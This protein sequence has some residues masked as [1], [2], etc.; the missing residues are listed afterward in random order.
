MGAV[1]FEHRHTSNR[2]GWTTVH[3]KLFYPSQSIIFSI[4]PAL[5]FSIA[6]NGEN[7]VAPP[8]HIYLKQQSITYVMA[9]QQQ[10]LFAVFFVT[11][12]V[13]AMKHWLAKNERRDNG[14]VWT[15][16]KDDNG[17]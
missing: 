17:C 8:E 3:F 5:N 6:T 4:G 10:S 12:R 9:L 1:D 2:N 14:V 13:A 7:K 11:F 15:W 16:G